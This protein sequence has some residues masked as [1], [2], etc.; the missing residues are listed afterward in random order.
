MSEVIP[1]AVCVLINTCTSLHYSNMQILRTIT[2][3]LKARD[4][5]SN[6]QFHPQLR[7]YLNLGQ[8]LKADPLQLLGKEHLYCSQSHICQG[9]H[10]L[11]LGLVG[12]GFRFFSGFFF[13]LVFAFFTFL[14][15]SKAHN[16]IW[17]QD[18]SDHTTPEE[19][20]LNSNF[21]KFK[22][23]FKKCISFISL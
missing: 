2:H 21:T 17:I 4:I 19:S 20:L 1:M 12:L 15:K 23:H 8:K 7:T 10:S 16:F 11:F 6:W 5:T 14:L 9:I 18:I 3:K 22:E 13:F